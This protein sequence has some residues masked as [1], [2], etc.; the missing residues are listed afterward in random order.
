MT[1]SKMTPWYPASVKPVR[2]GLY[3]TRMPGQT[4]P[5]GYQ[6]WGVRF[7]CAW[8][9]SAKIAEQSSVKSNFQ[10]PEWRGLA[11]QGTKP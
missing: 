8:D 7:W 9:N 1:N 6:K 10:N 5:D 11:A 4:S 2:K 3:Q